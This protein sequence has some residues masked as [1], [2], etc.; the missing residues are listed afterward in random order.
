M[1]Q[2]IKYCEQLYGNNFE[3]YRKWKNFT[4]KIYNL[5][6]TTHEKV[7]NALSYLFIQQI[8]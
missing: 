2:I 1:K 4:R 5:Q 7:Q 6:K 8:N 3:N